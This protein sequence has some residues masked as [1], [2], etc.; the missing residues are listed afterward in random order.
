VTI[1]EPLNHAWQSQ[2]KKERV[3]FIPFV[4]EGQAGR[5]EQPVK[6]LLSTAT[7]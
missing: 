7:N 5:A 6:R 1:T 4:K 2:R 3:T